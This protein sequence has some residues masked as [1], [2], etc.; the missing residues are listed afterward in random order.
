MMTEIIGGLG[1]ACE[2]V[3]NLRDLLNRKKAS[4]KSRVPLYDGVIAILLQRTKTRTLLPLVELTC[5]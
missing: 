5:I 4:A 1:Q 3:F 2:S